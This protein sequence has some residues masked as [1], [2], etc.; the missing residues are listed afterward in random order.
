MSC[1][2]RVDVAPEGKEM[3]ENTPRETAKIYQ[4]PVKASAPR[5]S[6]QAG[7]RKVAE[8]P[9]RV[10]T[11]EFGSGSYHDAAIQDAEQARHR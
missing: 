10:A 11:V 2:L 5:A 3:T 9:M 8:L 7:G 1:V 6:T 4:F